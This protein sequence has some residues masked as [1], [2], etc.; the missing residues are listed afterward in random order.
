MPD[1][2]PKELAQQMLRAAMDAAGDSWDEVSKEV[3][4]EL[5][6]LAGSLSLLYQ[7][8]LAGVVD[9]EQA[10]KQFAI[11]K[12]TA[13]A[14]KYTLQGKALVGAENAVNAALAAVRQFISDTFGWVIFF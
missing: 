4:W 6:I 14:W 1:I 10:K 8:Q 13:E 2:D 7:L 12:N 9:D 5:S 3:E 11:Q